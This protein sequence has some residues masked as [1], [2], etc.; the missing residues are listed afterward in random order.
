MA[1]R[2]TKLIQAALSALYYT[3][4][5][6]A[7]APLTRGIGVVFMMHH[8]RPEPAA[9]FEPNSIL[10]I[11]PEFLDAVIAQ[12]L[13]DG[14]DVVSLEQAHWRLTEGRFERPFACFTFD[15][16]YRD[17]LTHA[18]P[19]FRRRGLPFAIYVPTDYA[20]GHGDLWWLALEK[21]IGSVEELRLDMNG[22]ERVF[23]TSNAA[24]KER[25]FF[26]IYWWL[27]RIDEADAR[28]IVADLCAQ[29]GFDAAALCTQL[30]M[31]WD[32]IRKLAR[33]PLV[34]IGAHTRGHYAL[35]KLSISQARQEMETSIQRIEANLGRRPEHFSYPYGDA[36]SAGPR[37]FQL[38]RELG[39][40]T[41][42][43]TR[44][45]LLFPEHERH[46]TAL[47]RV[48]LNGDFQ[49]RR[50]VSALL[51]GAPTYLWNGMRKVVA[52]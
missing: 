30:V 15:D 42:V 17:N 23:V 20:D 48:S 18:Y 35:G 24:A 40:K 47:P 1:P 38:A 14:F 31:T 11:T 6:R 49:A 5:D 8:V 9:A 50:Y 13:D 34:T 37:E 27:R 45:G 39:M 4:A 2:S 21:V 19:V 52:T 46:L 16:G 29:I 26:E 43:T 22:R 10:K 36:D 3:G 41:A 51:S 7:L 44:K 25:T 28:K 12:V 33:D 32:E